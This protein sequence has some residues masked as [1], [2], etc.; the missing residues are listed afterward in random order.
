MHVQAHGKRPA[1]EHVNIIVFVIDAGAVKRKVRRFGS[2][3]VVL[4]TLLNADR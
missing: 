3:L 2:G 1:S 4:F